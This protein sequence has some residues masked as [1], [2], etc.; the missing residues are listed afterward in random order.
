[1]RIMA[2][3]SIFPLVSLVLVAGGLLLMFLILLAGAI[4]DGPV[5]KFYILQADTGNIPGAPPVSRWSYWN[6]CGV[7]NDRTVCGNQTYSEVHPA[8]PLDPASH[9]TFNTHVNIPQNFIHKH[10]YYYLM[11]RFMFAFMLIALTFGVFALFSGLLALCT[12][13]GSYLSGLL[14]LIA[15]FF[16]A[17]NASLMTAAYIKGRNN[18][19]NN[20]QSSDI[21]KYAFGFEW[22]A[23]ACFLISTVLFCIGGSA[24][25]DTTVSTRRGFFKGRRSRSTRSRGSFVHDKEYGS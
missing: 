16:Q 6:V 24:R 17:L 9:R 25:K 10:G 2:A 19:R 7:Q 11:T 1:M 23:F 22:A 15:L 13:L 3:R 14:T 18:F 20:G 21:G 8:F 12:R 4:D 5:N